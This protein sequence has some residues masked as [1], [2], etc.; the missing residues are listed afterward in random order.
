MCIIK[1]H[2]QQFQG[3][4]LNLG[5]DGKDLTKE[6]VASFATVLLETL[7]KERHSII[8]VHATW[9]THEILNAT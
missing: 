6:A 5:G 1:L 8:F 4:V 3:M 2:P 7:S 9:L